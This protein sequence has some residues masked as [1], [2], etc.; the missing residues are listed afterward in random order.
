M[1]LTL[2]ING[3]LGFV[4]FKHWGKSDHDGGNGEKKGGGGFDL[5]S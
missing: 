4:S 2:A 3:L 5:Y 1:T